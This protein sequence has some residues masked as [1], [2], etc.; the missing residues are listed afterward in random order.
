MR[1]EE[2]EVNEHYELEE[3]DQDVDSDRLLSEKPDERCSSANCCNQ[4]WRNIVAF[5][6]F[7]LCNNFGYVIMLSAAH[8]ILTKEIG[9]GNASEPTPTPSP[10]PNAT[11]ATN[12]LCKELHCNKQS[13]GIILL[14][15]ILP[16]L[17]IKIMAPWFMNRISY[18]IRIITCIL[19]SVAS[20]AVVAASHHVWLSLLGVVFAS[21]SAG[22]GE[23]TFLSFSSHFHKNTVSSWSSGTGAAGMVG[24]FSYASLA[25]LLGPRTTIWTMLVVP[26]LMVIA[27]FFIMKRP[28]PSNESV[29]SSTNDRE[30]LIQTRLSFSLMLSLTKPLLV[31]MAPL[32]TVYLAEYLINQGLTELL[33]YSHCLSWI[34]AASQYRWFQSLYQTGV[35]ISRSSVNIAPIKKLWV[36]S[37]LQVINF[38]FLFLLARLQFIPAESWGLVIMFIIVFYEGLLG[39]ATYV[40][41][42]YRITKEV[43]STYKEFSMGI[44]SVADSAG[45]S[46]AAGLAIPIHSYVC[47]ALR[48]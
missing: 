8:D 41:A 3:M 1:N 27:Y 32:F 24:A 48:V 14:A 45:I 2:N 40:N 5:W 26:A 38:I 13:T 47:H 33:T 15:D 20:Y 12:A 7:G 44:A 25:S 6:I 17:I 21:I 46:I 11:N 10:S 31:Y 22:F 23:I 16:T 36:L 18:H 28:P 35:F 19:F 9:S 37:L 30:A 42:Y 39:G 4:Y 34:T 29:L 43:A